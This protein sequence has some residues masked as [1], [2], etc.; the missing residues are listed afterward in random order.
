MALIRVP[1]D[2]VLATVNGVAL[3][4]KD[5]QPVSSP[6]PAGGSEQTL[7]PERYDFLLQR[8]I[9][10]EL[11]VQAARASGVELSESQKHQ[12]ARFQ[13]DRTQPEPGVIRQLTRNTAQTE[14]E[15]RDAAALML[16]NSLLARQGVSAHVTP[17]RVEEYYR[18]HQAEYG[19][20]PADARARED[21]WAKIDFQ[22][23]QLLAPTFQNEYQNQRRVFL[24]K[25]KAEAQITTTGVEG[26]T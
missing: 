13:A 3:T 5:L 22:V 7:S 23:R 15:L 10:R 4:L 26:R 1:V 20:L 8:A 14:F 11:T 12:L 18:A 2:Q 9:E 6:G 16:Q 25:L 17:E 21:A 19:E 24:D